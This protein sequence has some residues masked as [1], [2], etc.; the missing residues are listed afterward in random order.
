MAKYIEECR[1]RGLTP[2]QTRAMVIKTHDIAMAVILQEFRTV[3][4]V[5]KLLD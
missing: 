4:G 2:E 3:L 5:V 1:E